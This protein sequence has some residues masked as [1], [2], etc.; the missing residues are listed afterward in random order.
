MAAPFKY[1]SEWTVRDLYIKR[2]R[3]ISSEEKPLNSFH[4]SDF[5]LSGPSIRKFNKRHVFLS[6][7]E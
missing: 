7:A 1:C 2:S 4:L 5:L 3:G 6:L